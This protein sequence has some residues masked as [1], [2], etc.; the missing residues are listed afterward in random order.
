MMTDDEIRI[1]ARGLV[2]SLGQDRAA[3]KLGVSTK[4]ALALAAEARV[5]WATFDKV[6]AHYAPDSV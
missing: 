6:R 4:T 5:Q 2:K 3:A 1:L